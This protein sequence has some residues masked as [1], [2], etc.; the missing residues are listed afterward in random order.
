MNR[1]THV[2]TPTAGWVA[3]RLWGHRRIGIQWKDRSEPALF[4]ERNGYRRWWPHHS[5]KPAIRFHLFT[6]TNG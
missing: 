3:L 6:D 2:S 4:T 5:R 1:I